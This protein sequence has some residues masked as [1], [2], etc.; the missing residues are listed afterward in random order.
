M[1]LLKVYTKQDKAAFLNKCKK[2]N[3][4]LSTEDI[5]QGKDKEYF[6]VNVDI[7]EAIRIKQLFK[8]NPHFNIKTKLQEIIQQD[9]WKSQLSLLKLLK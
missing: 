4:H 5:K 6:L 7:N 9:A 2:F 3:I 8:N 1:P